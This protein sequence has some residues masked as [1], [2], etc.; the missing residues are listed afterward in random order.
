VSHLAAALFFT[1]ALLGAAV[2]IHLTVQAYWAEILL[3]LK[4]EWGGMVT[5]STVTGSA[6]RAK[7]P[8]PV[9][10]FARRHAGAF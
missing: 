6:G 8:A 5:G 1:L 7:A 3:A 10:A 2:A 9:R 4:G